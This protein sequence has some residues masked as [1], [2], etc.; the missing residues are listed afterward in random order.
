[1]LYFL[2]SGLN[3]FDGDSLQE[4]EEN[5]LNPN[6]IRSKINESDFLGSLGKDLLRKLLESDP[7]RRISASEALIHEYFESSETCRSR[8]CGEDATFRS[9]I[10][11]KMSR[12]WD[13]F[14]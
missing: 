10:Q 7:S 2:H 12:F 9:F 3:F 5:T 11:A 4:I 13:K 8:T 6:Y 14:Q 1:M